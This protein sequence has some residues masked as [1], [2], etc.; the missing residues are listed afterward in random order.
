MYIMNQ[1]IPADILILI[2]VILREIKVD[3][4]KIYSKM[5]TTMLI[6]TLKYF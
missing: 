5:Y 2:K 1:C 4:C 3:I 6:I